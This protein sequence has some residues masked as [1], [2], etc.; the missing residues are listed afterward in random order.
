[1]GLNTKTPAV[2]TEETRIVLDSIRRLVQGLRV[3][4]RTAENELGLSGAQLFVL[5]KLGEG[6]PMSVNDLAERTFT[7]QSSVSVV[8][9]RLVEKGLVHREPSEEDR[10]RVDLSLSA[11]GRK[12]LSRSPAAAQDDIISAMESMP[13]AA[14]KQL[15]QRLSELVTAMGLDAVPVQ[16]FFES[17]VKKG[18]KRARSTDESEG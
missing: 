15:A 4:A 8:V 10:R 9:Q 1:M 11:A 3:A 7:H 6:G 14:R 12:L 5:Q 16:M 13:A 18:A 17:D 2:A